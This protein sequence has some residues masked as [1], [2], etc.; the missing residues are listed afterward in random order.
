MSS[1]A[2]TLQFHVTAIINIYE[3]EQILIV[4]HD[5]TILIISIYLYDVYNHIIKLVS[6]ALQSVYGTFVP[7]ELSRL[8]TFVPKNLS[9][10]HI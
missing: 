7:R 9:L 4:F 2:N 1:D 10:I 6:I 5:I 3:S 8:R